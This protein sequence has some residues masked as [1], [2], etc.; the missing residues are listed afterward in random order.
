LL[1]TWAKKTLGASISIMEQYRNLSGKSGVQ[2]YELGSDFIKV[3]FKKG[4]T[5]L[6][7]YKS[8]SQIK[9]EKMK[10]LARK[11]LGLNSYIDRY[12]R[13]GYASKSKF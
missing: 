4:G 12:V 9:V 2:E 3:K 10:I 8:A 7:T 6:Y 5:Y 1:S 13:M 11:G